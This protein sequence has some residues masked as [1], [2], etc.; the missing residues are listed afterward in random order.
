M[1]ELTPS[2]IAAIARD[3]KMPS[4]LSNLPEVLIRLA[5]LH[6]VWSLPLPGDTADIG[7]AIARIDAH[8]RRAAILYREA[9][10]MRE[11]SPRSP[12]DPRVFCSMCGAVGHTADKCDWRNNV[13]TDRT[14]LKADEVPHH[15]V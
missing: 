9:M 2:E 5:H 8:V 14:C 4:I 7:A 6:D 10:R 15:A 13:R 1:I 11:Y 3:T 12:T